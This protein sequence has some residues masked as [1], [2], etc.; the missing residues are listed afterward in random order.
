[1]YFFTVICIYVQYRNEFFRKSLSRCIL[2]L[3]VSTLIT[4]TE[5]SVSRRSATTLTYLSVVCRQWRE[6]MKSFQVHTQTIA[7]FLLIF[8]LLFCSYL[9]LNY[10][11]PVD[12]F[13]QYLRVPIA[14]V[15]REFVSIPPTIVSRR[16][17]PSRGVKRHIILCLFKPGGV[18]VLA[19]RPWKIV[20]IGNSNVLV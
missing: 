12:G 20:Y 2:L 7:L 9:F 1:M 19:M 11:H 10:T 18:R 6:K 5:R 15:V 13:G 16:D 4:E 8:F 17:L 14:A 3:C